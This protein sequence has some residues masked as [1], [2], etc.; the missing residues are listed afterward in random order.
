MNNRFYSLEQCVAERL[1]IN[2]IG[3]S[4]YNEYIKSLGCGDWVFGIIIIVVICALIIYS[5]IRERETERKK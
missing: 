4:G 2:N 1:Q 5:K 3:P